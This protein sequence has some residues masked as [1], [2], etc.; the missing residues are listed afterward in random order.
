MNLKYTSFKLSIG[1][2]SLTDLD[3][4]DILSIQQNLKDFLLQVKSYID[5]EIKNGSPTTTVKDEFLFVSIDKRWVI[6][7]SEN[8]INIIYNHNYPNDNFKYT[9][10]MSNAKGYLNSIKPLMKLK[11][12]RLGSIINAIVSC[13]D[14]ELKE[15]INNEKDVLKKSIKTFQ[16]NKAENLKE[17]I[18][19]VIEKVFDNSLK[20]QTVHSQND[21]EVNDGYLLV[22][23]INTLSQ[24]THA[25]FDFDEINAFLLDTSGFI[26]NLEE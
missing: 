15:F 12:V 16:R 13:S 10:F 3:R 5:L 2:H 21:I 17:T 11:S 26:L 6:S 24:E 1:N 22:M 7:L 4:K 9:D 25:R 18:N 19:I 20:L 14:E 23:D 8:N